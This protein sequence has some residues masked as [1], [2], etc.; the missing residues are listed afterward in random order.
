MKNSN[1]LRRRTD[2]GSSLIVVLTFVIILSLILVSYLVTMQLDRVSTRNYAQTA[3]AQDLAMGAFQEVL[4]DLVTE[5]AAGSY[6]NGMPVANAVYNTNGVQVW[7]PSSALTAQPARIGY[8]SNSYTNDVS[9]SLLPPT[10]IRVS[11]ASDTFYTSPPTNYNASMLPP[12][13]AS[14]ASSSNYS[15]NGRVFTSARWNKPLLL[16]TTAPT[17]F[18]SA[19]PDWVYVTRGGSTVISTL[20]TN[21]QPTGD[22]TQTNPILGRYAFAVYD[23]GALLDAN[24]AGCPSSAVTTAYFHNKSA[25]SY[26]DL[27]QIPG[28]SSNTMLTQAQVDNFVNWRN[29]GGLSAYSTYTNLIINLFTNG[30]MSAYVGDSPLVGRQD[31]IDYMKS[32]GATNA[33]PYLGTFSRAITAPS[34]CPITPANATNVNFQYTALAETA[35]A[36]NRNMPNVRWP[37]SGTITHYKDDATTAT[38]NVNAGDPLLQSRF[39][40]A[41]LNWLSQADPNL[42]TA[43]SGNY[44]AAIQACF[45]LVWGVQGTA[46]GGNACWTYV[47]STGN[48]PVGRIKTLS[49]VATDGREPNFFELLKAAILSGS[50]GQF[51]GSAGFGNGATPAYGTYDYH[52]G[53]APGS[54]NFYIYSFKTDG[55][56]PAPATISDVQI[57]HIGANII[58]QYD[59]D[60]Y[61]TAIYFYYNGMTSRNDAA[62][63]GGNQ[64]FGETDMI[65]G[66][67]NLPRLV[68]MYVESATGDGLPTGVVTNASLGYLSSFPTPGD[69]MYCAGSQ[70]TMTGFE[71]WW[72]PLIWNPYQIPN[73]ANA[74]TPPPTTYQINGYGPLDGGWSVSAGMGIC[75]SSNQYETNGGFLQPHGWASGSPHFPGS[76]AG[77]TPV[78]WLAD[79]TAGTPIQYIKITDAQ[80]TNSVFYSQPQLLVTNV[81]GM[82]VPWL[83]NVTVALYQSNVLSTNMIAHSNMP[84]Y[85]TNPFVG[86]WAGGDTNYSGADI[87]NFIDTYA[88]GTLGQPI[89]FSMGWVDT[90]GGYHPYSYL[91]GMFANTYGNFYQCN[92]PADGVTNRFQGSC[93]P[94]PTGAEGFV[95]PD[96]RTAR[97]PVLPLWEVSLWNAPGDFNPCNGNPWTGGRKNDLYGQGEPNGSLNFPNP[98]T[99]TFSSAFFYGK[100][101][102]D[103]QVNSTNPLASTLAGLTYYADPDGVVRP[104]DGVFGNAVTGDGMQLYIGQVIHPGYGTL[105][106][107]GV[108]S[109]S[110][111]A[112]GDNGT[113]DFTGNVSHGRRP[114]VLNR[115]F[116]SVGELGYTYRDLPYKTLDFFTTAS[117]DAA[118]LDVFSV[119]D[120]AR[121]SNNELSSVVAGQVNLSHA[122]V[123]VIKAI[124]AGGSKKDFDPTYNMGTETTTMAQNIANY[125]ST[126]STLMSRADL[127]LKLGSDPVTGNGPIR[128][129]YTSSGDL[130]N[131]AYLEAPVRALADVVNTRTWDLLIDVVAQSGRMS[132]TATTLSD[133]IVDGER[134]YWLHVAIDRYTGKII[135][136]QLEPVY[137]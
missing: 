80:P 53:G 51:P 104:G 103:W 75:T 77:T 96:C 81:P 120:E 63:S 122:P 28:A 88:D 56:L 108:P 102:T 109:G 64:I 101:V 65:F 89:T 137:E 95:T 59:A 135:S 100:Y 49:E 94:S 99:Y 35:L 106:G 24:V 79:K 71:Q 25:V 29:K 46:N 57:M 42:G 69:P 60:S 129:A 16:G 112:S 110:P 87:H 118:L 43:P 125:M 9:T 31:M 105:Y 14:A 70:A 123:P 98:T 136:Q 40:L 17:A 132:P 4:S 66:Q 97:Y 86:F 133:F 30:F 52:N 36:T 2:R 47:G 3:K 55:T 92:T 121:V 13:R 23:E 45:G 68:G 19:P 12:N 62:A 83:T 11:R 82:A 8:S 76:P 39:S 73:Q 22:L 90:K 72:Q 124:L 61:P 7:M 134:R 114:V 20:S 91:T 38:Y 117:G 58:D 50:I 113:T 15:A 18:S 115:P 48:T 126:N 27:T 85:L 84:S 33:I 93:D 67:E 131:K 10:L 34:W 128:N 74:A 130:G 111:I 21:L 116:R 1:F 119:N 107:F 41:K 5:M 6:T 44:P 26:A 78:Q 32:I 54:D 37:S 127:V